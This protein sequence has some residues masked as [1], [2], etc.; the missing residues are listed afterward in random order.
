MSPYESQEELGN[1]EIYHPL[2]P[3]L[4][5]EIKSLIYL[6]GN[7]RKKKRPF[8]KRHKYDHFQEMLYI[9]IFRKL[10]SLYQLRESLEL[11]VN[12]LKESFIQEFKESAIIIQY[13][14][15][16]QKKI[17]S[18]KYKLSKKRFKTMKEKIN[19]EIQE[20]RENYR[21]PSENLNE[22][23]KDF[24]ASFFN[25]NVKHNKVLFSLEELSGELMLALR[26]WY[27]PRIYFK[28][29]G[30]VAKELFFGYIFDGLYFNSKKLNKEII[31]LE[32]KLGRETFLHNELITRNNTYSYIINKLLEYY[33]INKDKYP[34]LN[35]KLED[36]T[37][38]FTYIMDMSIK[39]KA[40][41]TREFKKIINNIDFSPF[42][43]NTR[44]LAIKG[45]L[46]RLFIWEDEGIYSIDF[47]LRFY[48]DSDWGRKWYPISVGEALLD[49]FLS[50]YLKN[51][52]F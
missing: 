50:D 28:D 4:N 27:V 18:L 5:N 35:E 31:E 37:Q 17:N 6:R 42:T 10:T 29:Y 22:I 1:F 23:L 45:F 12:D 14:E 2:M 25:Y 20:L 11:N 38:D 36:F 51:E 33:F 43:P 9:L 13:Q 46:D 7:D 3:I 15:L 49:D 44:E 21:N 40:K 19:K 16:I 47:Y 8:F 41:W 52:I 32:K 39:F 48:L 26:S 30:G 34:F 24:L